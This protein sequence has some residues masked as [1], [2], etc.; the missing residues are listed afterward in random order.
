MWK[1]LLFAACLS[2]VAFAQNTIYGCAKQSTG[3]LRQVPSSA[4][5][6]NNE[7]PL[8]WNIT[9]PAGPQGQTGPAGP[10]GQ[11]GP[12]GPQGQTGP[13]GPQGAPGGP[14][15]VFFNRNFSVCGDPS[16][17][18]TNS[19]TGDT[20]LTV[21]TLNLP[22]GD[23]VIQAKFRYQNNGNTLSGQVGCVFFGAGIGGLDASSHSNIP[24]GGEFGGQVDA[25][26]MDYVTKAEADDSHVYVHCFGPPQV[27]I[28]NI[29]FVATRANITFQ[30]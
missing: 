20:P 7:T 17:P 27:S 11:T 9:G 18:C 1:T 4:F 26:M 13:A 2:T 5:C 29:Q 16:V 8:S 21:A 3:D 14:S 12:T 19:L 30:Q 23:Y 28:V 24:T 10:Q 22:P 15:P 6:K 25:F